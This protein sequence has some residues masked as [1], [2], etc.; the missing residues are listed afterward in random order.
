[1]KR[2]YVDD[3]VSVI[4]PVYNLENYIEDTMIS[5]LDQTYSKIEIVV[6]NDC[7]TDGSENKIL[8]L[9]KKNAA[10]IKYIKLE[11]NSGAGIARNTALD[12]S[13]GQYVAFLDGDDLWY[14]SK[15]EKQ[16]QLLKNKK[17]AFGFSAIEMID[18][19]NQI[20]KSKRKI[21][22]SIDYKFLLKNT[23][24]ATSSVLIDRNLIGEFHMA[25][26]RS[27]QDYATWLKL[28]RKTKYAYGVDEVLVQYR[29]RE[30][31]LSSKKL[32]NIKKVWNIQVC[33]EGINPFMATIHSLCYAYNSVKKYFF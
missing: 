22:K 16:V 2:Q 27:G 13:K 30:G 5:A 3:L 23:M 32:E 7:S 31:S 29:R 6:V 25:D 28:L 26:R 11:E 4:I 10:K 20:V 15:L 17:G 19:N 33:E 8:K 1:M 24:I 18:E 12:V 9:A 14:D 21:K